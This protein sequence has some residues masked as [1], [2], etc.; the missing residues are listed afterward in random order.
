MQAHEVFIG[1]DVAKA[2]LSSLY[3][4]MRSTRAGNDRSHQPVLVTCPPSIDRRGV[5]R[6]YHWLWLGWR[7]RRAVERSCSMRATST[8]TPKAVGARGKTD[9]TDARIIARYLAE[10][11]A[12]LKPWMPSTAH[13]RICRSCSAPPWRLP[14]PYQM[15]C[16]G[17]GWPAERSKGGGGGAGGDMSVAG[18]RCPARSPCARAN[19]P[20]GPL[21]CRPFFLLC[22]RPLAADS[23]REA[24]LAD[25]GR[26]GALVGLAVVLMFVALALLRPG[27]H[28]RTRSDELG[29]IR[30]RPA[31]STGSA[32]R[33]GRDVFARVVWGTR[34]SLLAA[35][36]RCRSRCSGVRSV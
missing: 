16:R 29:A 36:S 26:R 14:T 4:R 7:M 17:L 22:A 5:H 18:R 20:H 28:R 19:A 30:K 33:I 12:A 25:C 11:H 31:S 13:R 32:R 3:L 8:S 27:S 10:H 23:V 34:A 15:C 24:R 6:R 9:R 2:T 1:V 35:W 21:T